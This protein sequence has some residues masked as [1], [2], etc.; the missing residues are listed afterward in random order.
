MTL[1]ALTREAIRA[2]WRANAHNPKARVILV[3]FRLAS[4]CQTWRSPLLLP[5]RAAVGS[6]Y[7][8]SVEWALGVELPWRT[9]VGPGLR[10]YH[11]QGLVVNDGA[12]IGSNVVLRHGV[13]LGHR[14]PGG[15]CPRIGNGV[16]I[17]AGAIV[18]GDVSIGDGARIGAGAIVVHNIPPRGV[19]I[20]AAARISGTDGAVRS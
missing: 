6:L 13:T 3:G 18:L 15:P 2:D 1:I 16:D 10:I 9:R 4:H 7:R 5:L 20:G 12:T 14:E 19:A 8:V 17:G 11:G